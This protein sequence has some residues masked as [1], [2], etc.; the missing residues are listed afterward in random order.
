MTAV[1]R[2]R[3]TAVEQIELESLPTTPP[4][5]GE[6]RVR[7]DACGVCGSDLHMYRGDHPVL[8]PPLVMGHEFVG[9]VVECG[10]GVERLGPGQRVVAM[11]GRGCG[12]CEACREGHSN[13]CEHL[14]VIGGHL[15]GGLAEEVVLPEDQFVPIP[16]W[17]PDEQAALIEVAAVP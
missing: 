8:R 5:P 13:W 9:R 16:D 6:V 11:A 17:I 7:V 15:P 1:Q 10:P 12:V 3:L 14:Q 4:G 2:A